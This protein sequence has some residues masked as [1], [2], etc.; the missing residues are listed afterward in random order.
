MIIFQRRAVRKRAA[1]DLI[2]DMGTDELLQKARGKVLEMVDAGKQLA[3]LGNKTSTG[4]E[5]IEAIFRLLN[6]RELQAGSVAQGIVDERLL[7]MF[8][9]STYIRD[10]KILD[11]FVHNLRTRTHIETLYK[12]FEQLAERWRTDGKWPLKLPW[13]KRKYWAIRKW[14]K[15]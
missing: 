2:Y 12:E 3:P 11:G 5:E 10:W 13:T 1:L 7:R 6:A 4:S 8:T 14:L 9:N 15:G